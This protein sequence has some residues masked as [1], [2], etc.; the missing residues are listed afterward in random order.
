MKKIK[1]KLTVHWSYSGDELEDLGYDIDIPEKVRLG[2]RQ[3][4]AYNWKNKLSY[5]VNDE[6]NDNYYIQR[7]LK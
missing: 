4:V 1:D 6:G 2:E 5:I 7:I 3:Y